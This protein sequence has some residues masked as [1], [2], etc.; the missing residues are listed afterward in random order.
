MSN[1]T[2]KFSYKNH[3]DDLKE[4]SPVKKQKAIHQVLTQI[5][6]DTKLH[7]AVRVYGS[8]ITFAKGYNPTYGFQGYHHLEIDPEGGLS[9]VITEL[10]YMADK[11][12]ETH[13]SKYPL[14]VKKDKV[15]FRGE[16]NKEIDAAKAVRHQGVSGCNIDYSKAQNAE[17]ILKS[18]E[19][20]IISSIKN[21]R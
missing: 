10:D 20:A 16:D 4:S 5:L 2:N 11:G 15:F 9:I 12:S 18:L 13:N 14:Y 7:N 21:A 3:L 6:G 8:P 1:K 19:E 17:G